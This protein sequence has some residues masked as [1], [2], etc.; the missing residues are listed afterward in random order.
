MDEMLLKW[1]V[2]ARSAEDRMD[3]V[4]RAAEQ[5][6]MKKYLAYNAPRSG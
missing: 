4:P 5:M 3:Y 6:F 2:L 1:C